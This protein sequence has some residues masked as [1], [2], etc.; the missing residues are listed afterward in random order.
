M[1]LTVA[2]AVLA[3]IISLI[4]RVQK[5]KPVRAHFRAQIDRLIDRLID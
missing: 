2:V 5:G 1:R 3:A 4:L